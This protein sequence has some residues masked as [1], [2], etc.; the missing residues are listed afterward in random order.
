MVI[1]YVWYSRVCAISKI[2]FCPD[3]VRLAERGGIPCSVHPCFLEIQDANSYQ[4]ASVCC[5]TDLGQAVCVFS[6]TAHGDKQGRP[7]DVLT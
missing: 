3:L 1:V 6:V 7:A 4:G 2:L 5:S